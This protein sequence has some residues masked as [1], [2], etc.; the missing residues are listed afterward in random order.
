MGFNVWVTA[1]TPFR[2]RLNWGAGGKRVE[3]PPEFS[4]FVGDLAPEVTDQMLQQLFASHFPSTLGAKVRHQPP[5]RARSRGGQ[6]LCGV[7]CCWWTSVGEGVG[8]C[9]RARPE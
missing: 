7:Q 5:W 9:G 2:F 6:G 8:L 4:V 3:T 1:G